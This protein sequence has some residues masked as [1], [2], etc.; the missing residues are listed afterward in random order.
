MTRQLCYLKAKINKQKSKQTKEQTNKQQRKTKMGREIL[1][2]NIRPR[3]H[4]MGLICSK[5]SVAQVEERTDP[6][7]SLTTQGAASNQGDHGA[8]PGGASSCLWKLPG[9]HE[10]GGA[11]QG[12]LKN[13]P[14]AA[15]GCV[16]R[17]WWPRD[18]RRIGNFNLLQMGSWGTRRPLG[19]R[20]E[21]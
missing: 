8:P 12:F 2:G 17:Q 19:S 9:C 18:G 14:R 13:G 4:E 7:G 5:G 15:P 6:S 20:R 11:G 10:V 16:D 1:P 3:F 21:N